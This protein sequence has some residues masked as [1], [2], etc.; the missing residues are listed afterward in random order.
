ML[1]TNILKSAAFNLLLISASAF[2]YAQ[3]GE[4]EEEL[5]RLP[6]MPLH[7]PYI[8]AHEPSETYYLYSANRSSMT[9]VRGVATM[10]YKSKNL[11]EWE[12][13]K[14]VFQV[15]ETAFA[16]QGGWAPEVHE[17]EGR[18][19]LFVTLHDNDKALADPETTPNPTYVRGTIAAVS[20]T[21]DGPF[22]MIDE[23]SAVPPSEFMTLDGT[24]YLD[25]EEQPWMVYAHEWIQR[26]DGTMEAIRLNPDDLSKTVGEPIHLFKASDAP[27][28]NASI[29]PRAEPLHNYVTDGPAL[30]RTK[31]DH[32]LMLWSSYEN[33]SYVQTIGRSTTGR[34]QGPWE[35]LPPMVKGHSG[36]GM[37]FRTFEGELMMVLH[38]PFGAHARG[39]FYDIEDRGDHF[40]AV[41]QRTD[42]DGDDPGVPPEPSE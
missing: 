16:T 14:I 3:E 25:K 13:P 39:K 29:T 32:L 33:G 34:L 20:D 7:D 38:R 1:N 2:T 4:G 41:K 11:L 5:L 19:Y 42:L 36:H 6:N 18:Y 24:L 23:T 27:W 12:K 31:D 15:P 37:F 40:V 26:I 30:Y 10:V 35:Q 28:L 21:P 17:Y 9:S 22:E 8:V